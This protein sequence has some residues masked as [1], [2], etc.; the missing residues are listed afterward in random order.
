[1]QRGAIEFKNPRGKDHFSDPGLIG[2]LRTESQ[3]SDLNS[4]PLSAWNA[5]VAI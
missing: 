5:R 4:D 3:W 2:G 1:M